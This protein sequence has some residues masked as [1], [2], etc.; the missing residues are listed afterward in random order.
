M[1]IEQH[2]SR[3]GARHRAHSRPGRRHAVLVR[4]SDDEK[5]LID[6]AAA[7]AQLT[8]TG[9]TAK[10]AVAAASRTAQPGGTD[11]DELKDLQRDL[12]AARR[13]VNMFGANVNQAAAAYHST[14]QLPD[15]AGE[16]V[17]LCAAAVARLDQ[18]TARIDRRLR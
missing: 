14:G 18:V 8:P 4:L 13:A 5:R 9:Y 17:R 1:E 11:I 15:W 7:A 16:A 12:F 6:E 3:P 10:A 2:T